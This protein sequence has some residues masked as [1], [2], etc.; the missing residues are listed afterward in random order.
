VAPA[1]APGPG[2]P[3]PAAARAAALPPGASAAGGYRAAVVEL[4]VSGQGL[5]PFNATWQGAVVAAVNDAIGA[6]PHSLD[7]SSIGVRGPPAPALG[8]GCRPRRCCRLGPRLSAVCLPQPCTP[9]SGVA[10]MCA[11][12]QRALEGRA[13]WMFWRGAGLHVTCSVQ[14]ARAGGPGE[15]AGPR[16]DARAPRG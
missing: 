15:P 11:G 4:L 16:C 10:L 5:A 2:A 12:R 14:A 7:I 3:G 9:L 8:R 13:G 1:P 6:V